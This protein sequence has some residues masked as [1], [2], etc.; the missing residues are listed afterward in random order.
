MVGGAGIA[1]AQDNNPSLR[2]DVGFALNDPFTASCQTTLVS[3]V[4]AND[5]WTCVMVTAG[6]CLF[7]PESQA[8]PQFIQSPELGY[9]RKFE[10]NFKAR[11][12]FQPAE[13]VAVVSFHEGC[14]RTQADWVV[15]LH[16]RALV[17][18]PQEA[19]PSQ[20]LVASRAYG[21]LLSGFISPGHPRSGTMGLEIVMNQDAGNKSSEAVNSGD[22]GGG[23]FMRVPS[24]LELIGVLNI[25]VYHGSS[26]EE[27]RA[28]SQKYASAEALGSG[29]L[30]W[31]EKQL[32][33]YGE[34]ERAPAQQPAPDRATR[35][36]FLML[37]NLLTWP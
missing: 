22:S 21:K 1:S 17:G 33:V 10:V 20:V 4:K 26:V 24:G 35:E 36:K 34:S 5:G 3:R 19:L 27:A 16:G 32:A 15:P 9:L 6:H 2:L 7:H 12:V 18:L 30:A 28:R 29:D 11:G 23:I 8:L 37:D 31:I 13:D 14:E 25:A